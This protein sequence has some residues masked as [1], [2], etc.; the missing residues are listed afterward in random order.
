MSVEHTKKQPTR[1][2]RIWVYQQHQSALGKIKAIEQYSP[3]E[4][5]L[6]IIS[7]DD[8]LPPVID[9]ATDIL[10]D[11]QG[12]AS[13]ENCADMTVYLSKFCK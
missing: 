11:P 12:V 1:P 2:Q 13:Q 4:I 9:D 7:I 6:H 3:D 10:P 8:T 5:E